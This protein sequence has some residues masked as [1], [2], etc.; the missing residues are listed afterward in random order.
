MKCNSLI[1]VTDAI[2]MPRA[3]MI[4]RK[5]DIEPIPAPTNHIIKHSSLHHRYHAAVNLKYWYD[6]RQC[7]NILEFSGSKWEE[8]VS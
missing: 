3:M 7:T 6:G 8:V 1:L 5:L 2:H 4:F